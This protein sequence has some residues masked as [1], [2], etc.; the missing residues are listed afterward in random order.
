MT[1]SC[2]TILEENMTGPGSQ[3]EE[4]FALRDRQGSCVLYGYLGKGETPD[5]EQIM[6]TAL[7]NY[8]DQK[9]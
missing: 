7:E 8:P 5:V 2:S 1:S 4:R 9:S 3:K 6:T